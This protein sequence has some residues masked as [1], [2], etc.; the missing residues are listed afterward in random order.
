MKP[1]T[2]TEIKERLKEIPTWEYEEGALHITL[3]FENFKEAFAA[4][5]RISF[6]AEAQQHHPQWTNTYNQLR[7]SLSSHDA[8]GVTDK[9]FKLALSI[10]EILSPD[11]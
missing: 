9:D 3:E 10:E 11:P 1:L 7:I 8:D 5:T 6:E 2:Q 4:M